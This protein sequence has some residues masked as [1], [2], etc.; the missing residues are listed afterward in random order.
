MRSHTTMALMIVECLL[1][2]AELQ[3]SQICT[4]LPEGTL[5]LY[6]ILYIQYNIVIYWI[7]LCIMHLCRQ[8]NPMEEFHFS[9]SKFLPALSCRLASTYHA[10]THQTKNCLPICFSQGPFR[11]APLCPSVKPWKQMAVQFPVSRR[12]GSAA[13]DRTKDALWVWRTNKENTTWH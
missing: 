4:Y 7:E 2:Q 12:R 9:D 10:T 8:S 1:L 13:I 11:C 3:M 6:I 5:E